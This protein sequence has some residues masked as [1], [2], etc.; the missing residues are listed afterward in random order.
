MAYVP[1]NVNVYCAAYAGCLSGMVPS[2]RQPT[3]ST[4]ADY[5]ANAIV[6]GAFAQ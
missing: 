4:P 2:E 1:S 3:D 6:A 5:A